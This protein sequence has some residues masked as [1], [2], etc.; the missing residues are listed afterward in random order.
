MGD[1]SDSINLRELNNIKAD[2]EKQIEVVKVLAVDMG[3]DPTMIRDTS[4]GYVLIP[5]LV[6]KSN[7]I[8]ALSNLEKK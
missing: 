1:I 4:G 2:L 5:L 6:A 7:V 8:V 3:I